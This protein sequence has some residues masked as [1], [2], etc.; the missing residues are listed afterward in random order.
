MIRHRNKDERPP[1]TEVRERAWLSTTEPDLLKK[2]GNSKDR[3]RWLVE[4]FARRRIYQDKDRAPEA[5]VREVALFLLYQNGPGTMSLGKMPRLSAEGLQLLSRKIEVGVRDF[6]E[7]LEWTVPINTAVQGRPIIS[8]S[9][10]RKT[11]ELGRD[12]GKSVVATS[13]RSRNSARTFTLSFQL[14]AQDLVAS[15]HEFLAKCPGCATV[16]V[17]DD[18]RQAY[19]TVRCN[20]ASRVRKHRSHIRGQPV[21]ARSGPPGVIDQ[22]GVLRWPGAPI[23][24]LNRAK[25]GRDSSS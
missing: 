1:E 8:R 6:L 3:L 2:L 24:D 22:H 9:V 5:L 21:K 10:C 18:L 15:A 17:R 4:D 23:A 11:I 19:C 13:W 16:F 25:A 14:A 12:K 7:G 20:A